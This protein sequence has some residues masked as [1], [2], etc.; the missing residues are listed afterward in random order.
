MGWFRIVILCSIALHG[1]SACAFYQFRVWPNY[2]LLGRSV[3]TSGNVSSAQQWASAN[4]SL[5]QA[6]AVGEHLE[7]Q[8]ESYGRTHE[9]AGPILVSILVPLT[10]AVAG[11]AI[12][13]TTGAPVAALSLA[14]GSAFAYGSALSSTQRERIYAQ[15]KTAT[16][17]LINTYRPVLVAQDEYVAFR[18]VL[19]QQMIPAA[20][21]RLREAIDAYKKTLPVGTDSDVVNAAEA[22]VTSLADVHAKGLQA[23]TLF[24]A[25]GFVLVKQVT[26]LATEVN[27]A[28]ERTELDTA[29]LKASLISS[30]ASD[31]VVT[32]ASG[33]ASSINKF[34]DAYAKSEP[35][36]RAEEVKR[37]GPNEAT[38]PLDTLNK[39]VADAVGAAAPV[40]N[41]LL[42]LGDNPLQDARECV[43]KAVAAIQ[44]EPLKLSGDVM[45]TIAPGQTAV[46]TITGGVRPYTVTPIGTGSKHLTLTVDEVQTAFARLTIKAADNATPGIY[47]VEITDKPVSSTRAISV[48]VRPAPTFTVKP[49]PASVKQG[50]TVTFTVTGGTAPYMVDVI[51]QASPFTEVK[52]DDKDPTK[53]VAKVKNDAAVGEYTIQVTSAEALVGKFKVKVEAK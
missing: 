53:L 40:Q 16:R 44:L 38:S 23:D 14:G 4:A 5:C 11:L 34:R 31:V 26:Q 7:A 20:R 8:Y 2:G 17:C 50:G 45:P 46:V 22:L 15:G 36:E 43:D 25:G 19:D 10:A 12:T 35:K 52:A 18:D 27:R 37:R 29:A 3:S 1:L 30:F 51:N 48:T 6:L 42:R 41:V 28:L 39:A 13:G 47:S 33:A 24:R 32:G 21:G 49:E 9:R